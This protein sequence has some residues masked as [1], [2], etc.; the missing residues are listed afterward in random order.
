MCAQTIKMIVELT[1]YDLN[2]D[3]AAEIR[4]QA[5]N[6]GIVP[7]VVPLTAVMDSYANA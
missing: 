7:K 6:N 3:V 5:G 1:R 2:L 4:S